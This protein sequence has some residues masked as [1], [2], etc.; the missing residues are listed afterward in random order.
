MSDSSVLGTVGKIVPSSTTFITTTNAHYAPV[1]TS[2]DVC[3]WLA[4]VCVYLD[5]KEYL[6]R[7]K[8][9]EMKL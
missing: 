5:P 7:I 3:V 6:N 1:N 4:M 2:L 8:G 9:N